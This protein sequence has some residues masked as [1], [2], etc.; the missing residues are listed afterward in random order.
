M[1]MADALI[2]AGKQFRMLVMPEQNHRRLAMGFTF[3]KD[4][5]I[6]LTRSAGFLYEAVGKHFQESLIRG[7]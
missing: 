1:K 6:S 5:T 3:S 2:K 7:R 4:G